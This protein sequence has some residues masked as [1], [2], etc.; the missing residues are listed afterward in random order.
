MGP[1]LTPMRTNSRHKHGSPCLEKKYPNLLSFIA[2][3]GKNG[4]K[5]GLFGVPLL[6]DLWAV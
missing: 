1:K 6:S 4:A 5:T 2:A 3:H